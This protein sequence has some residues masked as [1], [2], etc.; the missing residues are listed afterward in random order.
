MSLQLRQ[1]WQ[2][3]IPG[4]PDD[5]HAKDELGRTGLSILVS[6]QD[7][8]A[9]QVEHLLTQGADVN[10]ADAT[11]KTALHYVC[12][13]GRL[14]ILQLLL[15]STF[16]PSDL[17]KPD[18]NGWRPVHHAANRG[19]GAEVSA[20]VSDESFLLAFEDSEAVQIKTANRFISTMH[21]NVL[22]ATF[23]NGSH[24]SCAK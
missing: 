4:F 11:G 20:Q 12:A 18:P 16:A 2:T 15:A 23:L 6:R 3:N 19:D 13:D 22:V 5:P 14:D 17:E 8:P 21:C 1:Y 9:G 10:K 7:A 24:N